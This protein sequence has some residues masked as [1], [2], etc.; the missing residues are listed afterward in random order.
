M[1]AWI[2]SSGSNPPF[3]NVN[4][5]DLIIRTQNS[6]DKVVIGSGKDPTQNAT[7][8]ASP[9]QVG[10][11]KAPDDNVILDVQGYLQVA[12][13]SNV[14]IA[15]S[16]FASD[17]AISNL[18]VG[19]LTYAS[20]TAT[21]VAVSNLT[22]GQ[23]TTTTTTTE[24]LSASNA[25]VAS[26]LYVGGGLYPTS[27]NG[28]T[29][30]DANN[31]FQ[32]LWL[33]G[34]SF[35]IGDTTMSQ[36][37]NG[38][39]IV[40]N[41]AETE[42]RSVIA[43]SV[44]IGGSNSGLLLSESN[45]NLVVYSVAQDGTQTA[46]DTVPNITSTGS[47]IAISGN[48]DVEG[49]VSITSTTALRADSNAGVATLTL[50][51]DAQFDTVSIK[52]NQTL[53]QNRLG[54]STDTPQYPLDVTG[55]AR[56]TNL[57]LVGNQLPFLVYNDYAD[58]YESVPWYGISAPSNNSN[59]YLTGKQGITLMTSNA[60]VVIDPLTIGLGI[61]TS[62][63]NTLLQFPDADNRRKIVLSEMSNN[64]NQVMGLGTQADTFVF[65]VPSASNRFTFY[66][67]VDDQTTQELL[68]VQGDANIKV[69]TG[70]A[71]YNLDIDGITKT[72]TMLLVGDSVD[73]VTSGRAISAGNS[74]LQPGDTVSFALGKTNDVC[75]Q[76]EI[77]YQHV[78]DNS[79]SNVLI[80]GLSGFNVMGVSAN[81]VGINTTQPQYDLD[82]R[83]HI[84]SDQDG[85]FD[86]N[87][88]VTGN[89]QTSSIISIEG[90]AD[91]ISIG[92]DSNTSVVNI[93]G[94]NTTIN[95]GGYG[96]TVNIEGSL[97]WIDTVN[98]VVS[99][100]TIVLNRGGADG[101]AMNC[102]IQFEENSNLAGYILVNQTDDGFVFKAPAPATSNNILAIN[103]LSNISFNNA[104]YISP[105]TSNVGFGS[106]VEPAYS[107]HIQNSNTPTL[108]IETL[109][110]DASSLILAN[111]NAQWLWSGP[112]DGSNNA[113]QLSV[114]SNMTTGLSAYSTF[115]TVQ[116]DGK[117][118]IGT[119]APQ[120]AID[121]VGT[122][123]ASAVLVNGTAISAGGAVAGAGGAAG[124]NNQGSNIYTDCN[125]GI[126]NH[127]PRYDL[128]VSGTVNASQF[129]VNGAA[130]TAGY[131]IADQGFMYT[132]SNVGINVSTPGYA[133]D[134]GGTIN[135][136]N[137]FVNGTSI[138]SG[139]WQLN[140]G[141]VFSLSNVGVGTSIPSKPLDVVG[142]ARIT[143]NMTAT[144]TLTAGSLSVTGNASV[145]GALT[146]S[147]TQNLSSLTWGDGIVF[148]NGNDRIY[149]DAGL[150]ALVIN[151][152][153]TSNLALCAGESPSVFINGSNG[154][155][156]VLNSNPAY[157]L[158]VKG[159]LHASNYANVPWSGLV[160][161]PS[162][163]TV[164]TSGSYADLTNRPS[165]CNLALTANYSDLANRPSLCNL[166]LTANYSDINHAPA[167]C[168]LALSA[169]YSDINH[170]PALCNL[171]L[172]GAW[173]DI[174]SKP[175]TLSA[176][177]TNDLSNFSG[178]VVFGDKV[179]IANASP[180]YA[181]DINGAVSAT[182]YCNV[183][184]TKLVN[185]PT[186]CNVAMSG[187]FSDLNG[188]PPLSY[189][190]N[191]IN[192]F[193]C[194]VG[195]KVANPQ[196]ALHVSGAVYATSYCNLQWSMINNAPSF[197][198]PSYSNLVDAPL[199]LSQL[200]NDLTCFT[201]NVGFGGNSNPAYAVDVAGAINAT[202][203][204]NVG[205]S[206]I[207]G[208]P[209]LCN[210]ALTGSWNDVKNKPNLSGLV[211]D[212][213]YFGCNI[214]IKNATPQYPLHVN[215]AIYATAYCNL[216]WSMVQSTP[217]FCNVATSGAYGDLANTPSSLSQFTN[218]LSNFA[219]DATF[220]CNL[221]ASQATVTGT[222]TAT[223][224][225]NLQ[226]SMIQN[227][228]TFTTDYNQLVNVPALCNVALSGRYADLTGTPTLC[229]VAIYGTYYALP[230]I[231]QLSVVAYRGSNS[232]NNLTGTPSLCNVALSGSYAALSG[233]PSNL[234][235]FNN[236]LSNFA[237]LSAGTL[238]TD[239]TLY[240]AG[241]TTFVGT[242]TC[243]SDAVVQG[244]LKASTITA[245]DTDSIMSIGCTSNVSTINIGNNT[246]T[247]HMINIGT[248]SAP[249]KSNVISIGG[250]TDTV[251]I[252]GQLTYVYN[253]DTYSSNHTF[254]F[255]QGGQV[256]S[257]AGAG[258][259]I[260]EA[261][262]NAAYMQISSDRNSW[263]FRTP[264][265]SNDTTL[266]MSGSQTTIDGT[267]TTTSDTSN[268]GIG[269]TVPTE[270][271]QV[272]GGNIRIHN[273]TGASV[274]SNALIF[275]HTSLSNFAMID[276]YN[277]NGNQID[278]RMY[279]FSNGQ[280]VLNLALQGSNVGVGTSNPSVALHVNGSVS[281]GQ[282]LV[283]RAEMQ[284]TW[285]NGTT[286][287]I[288][289]PATGQVDLYAP[290]TSH[291]NAVMTMLSSGYVGIGT[292][293]P[294][295][296]LQVAGT[297]ATQSIVSTKGFAVNNV[298]NSNADGTPKDGLGYSSACNVVLSGTNGVSVSST[299]PLIVNTN[300][301][302]IGTTVP[303]SQL[304]VIGNALVS[305]NLT[306]NYITCSCN[307]TVPVL[308]A[309]NLTSCNLV[310]LSNLVLAVQQSATSASNSAFSN[311]WATQSSN[312]AYTL[313]K[314]GIGKSNP[315]YP[316]D[317][318]GTISA[319][320]YCNITYA[321][322]SGTPSLSPVAYAG[323]NAYSN[324]TGTPALCNLATSGAW[325]D[326]SGKP[327]FA[328]V[329]TSGR[330]A[331]LVS[332][333]TTLSN[334]TNNLTMFPNQITFCNS[335]GIKTSVPAY[336]LDVK[337]T[338][339]ACNILVNGSNLSSVITPGGFWQYNTAF[340]YTFSNVG[341]GTSSPQALLAVANDVCITACNAPLNTVAGKG[342][343]M[344]Y[345]TW[346]N[347]DSAYIQSIDRTSNKY[348][349]MSIEASNIRLGQAGLANP[350]LFVEYDGKVGVGTT[351]PTQV[352]HV[353]G[354]ITATS[355][356][357]VSYCNLL[358]QPSYALV[359]NSGRYTDLSNLPTYALVANSG[360][361]TDLSN[362][363][364]F[365]SI[366]Y[367]GSNSYS[368]LTGQPTNLSQFTNDLS[369]F[370]ASNITLK[371]ATFSNSTT[372]NQTIVLYSTASPA[373]SNQYTGFG[374]K[375]GDLTHSLASAT[376]NHVFTAGTASN[377]SNELVRFTGAGNVGI[378][379]TA[380]SAKLHLTG[381]NFTV[382]G[383]VYPLITFM[384]NQP[385]NNASGGVQ[386]Q[387]CAPNQYNSVTML[388]S[389]SNCCLDFVQLPYL[390][391]SPL[392]L[393]HLA[394]NVGIKT[395]TPAY[396]LD[397][398]GTINAT[399]FRG[400]TWSMLS[401]VPSF[402]AV[403]YSGSN[404]YANLT[405][406][407]TT[408]TQFTNNLS[409]FTNTVTFNSNVGIGVVSP[410][411]ALDVTGGTI[412][413]AS[414]N[415]TSSNIVVQSIG[416]GGTLNAGCDTAT[417]ALNVGTGANLTGL[418]IATN[419]GARTAIVMGA[420][421]DSVSIQGSNIGLGGNGTTLSTGAGMLTLNSAGAL[422][423]GAGC[424]FQIYENSNATAYIKVS[425][426]RSSFLMKTPAGTEMSLNL[427]GN[428]ISFN[429]STLT[430]MLFINGTTG[431]VGI[432]TNSPAQTLD[433]AGNVKCL[434]VLTTSDARLKTNIRPI[435]GSLDKLR[436]I[437]G[438]YFDWKDTN[439]HKNT[440]HHAGVLA[441][442]V[443]DVL[444][445]AVHDG[446]G[447]GMAV[448]YNCLIALCVNAIKEQQ[449]EIDALKRKLE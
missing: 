301:V 419:S 236:D 425:G 293:Q 263:L 77:T 417:T 376:N 356:C 377:A 85:L 389:A 271:L 348:Y 105:A 430:N 186:L 334:F 243:D 326:I 269:T 200:T 10:I 148:N 234:G 126:K 196:Y 182:S 402:A 411:V 65:Q 231:P 434:S 327:A 20:S 127:T 324:L 192:Y 23:S 4:S 257:A 193:T 113:L 62:N 170:A 378:G 109:S 414:I 252:P 102:G 114:R 42:M 3:S 25:T 332:P 333:P 285:S 259:F 220:S 17:A 290:N 7:L 27:D 225:S 382:D 209:A 199:N 91:T 168:N 100:K 78:G 435:D 69:G 66:S 261:G 438:V 75:D 255:N 145:S 338:I 159:T 195:I 346:S 161:V 185:L 360:R 428:N 354:A 37:P 445:E 422:L 44:Q 122:I 88:T 379:N 216:S 298:T 74:L 143:G 191:N 208:A 416:S 172:T 183:D 218:D 409:N 347:Q 407:P 14:Y 399:A 205:W 229:N 188:V 343:Y 24:T 15:N 230:D 258:I 202:T 181:L 240:V 136:Q 214:G 153:T 36:D 337:G 325:T 130:F 433:V 352:L 331:D 248:T 372:S 267:L 112:V 189:F 253:N 147:G 128:D 421:N 386:L 87:L 165:L 158:D 251:Y 72:S 46:I 38:N 150:G 439:T 176:I 59:T 420:S 342:I 432:G 344:R 5:N 363:P 311:A 11:N 275:S 32:D 406:T 21:S 57:M 361:Y 13:D 41:N 86:S 403:A 139:F 179:G 442:Q 119:D 390:Q 125:I 330:Y 178:T 307:L 61:G 80:L 30:G 380:P 381:G 121:V 144:Q 443:M 286:N 262:C 423:S 76:G 28:A 350:G 68:S 149:A 187:S 437:E 247:G 197:A 79:T 315:A 272:Q 365:A 436:R 223:N 226:W 277:S 242:A 89:I 98:T 166:A 318:S 297:V 207:V 2:Q 177:A 401:N 156:G 341:V 268:V 246:S 55:F 278:L 384:T 320:T 49:D 157:E 120:F 164:A 6:T 151:V 194:N 388:Y 118:G 424:G 299:G 180:A 212:L 155:V 374:A 8:Y 345:S 111:S 115:I 282:S 227:V 64:Q 288:N 94:S 392:Y 141:N 53:V 405:G 221:Q 357:N 410:S 266:N 56:L 283:Y 33:G 303:T 359:A 312:T 309:S 375:S 82:V 101:S 129:Y 83:G 335:V 362:L 58:S 34:Q 314:V 146:V 264:T 132:T 222:L 306:A 291:S 93:G 198:A 387:F 67:A 366:A 249:G 446:G 73:T 152:D 104:L 313:G 300:N 163:Q 215:G 391:A 328:T 12:T 447:S 154:F 279:T 444:P 203:Y 404:T 441:Q 167:L 70:Q 142:D 171:A 418:N 256:G 254:T 317:V 107:V 137:I 210:I 211:N 427:T 260:V 371:T 329:A 274:Q 95:I 19:T 280:S 135:A 1:L 90:V 340:E 396:D 224:Y 219:R 385:Y 103:L 284:G 217:S 173:A 292:T 296:T 206:N 169:N 397:V 369:N 233:A 383:S 322:V 250:P 398:N 175:G 448:D 124:W 131:W 364:T 426:D 52:G 96:D 116:D 190:T 429:N 162:F 302:G 265:S 287:L 204:C 395:V 336:D 81:G 367:F 106:A 31:R 394:S 351:A 440:Q 97:T 51:P 92:A 321:M 310:A 305:S 84:Y 26:N 289:V 393:L 138:A 50:N 355:Y 239:G 339:N 431:L 133:L 415:V 449:R 54:I 294:T 63:V 108:F 110:N 368:N 43:A 35:H 39:L 241:A 40:T 232:Y 408:L 295:Q 18:S 45:N 270:K 245:Q 201:C 273:V 134:V 308:T 412:K 213:T 71:V 244:T 184:Y 316:L 353:N 370:T 117:I 358:Y 276:S 319:T 237:T 123:N 140:G 160:G 349:N 238:S 228:P 99:D 373:N 22:V 47:N 400:V 9:S 323:C 29:L 60:A 281:V 16:M 304:H 174:D 413:C 48:L 235:Q